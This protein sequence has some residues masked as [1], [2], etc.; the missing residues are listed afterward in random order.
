MSSER[1]AWAVERLGIRPR[2]RVL[3]AGCGHGV[4]V[5]LIAE[6]LDGGVVLA[7]DRSPRMIEAATRRNAARIAAGVVALQRAE[8]A[9]ADLGEEPF[10]RVLAIHLPVLQRGD[11]AR[12]LAVLRDHM[13][14]DA[15]LHVSFRPH[16]PAEVEPIA[17]H[18]RGALEANGFAVARVETADLASGRVASVVG[19]PRDSG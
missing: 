5:S 4:A 18:V 16:R 3:E 12:E 9:D 1:I 10:D 14:P 17:A 2:H 8:L 15:E 19:A 6:R 11:P 13:A 7:I